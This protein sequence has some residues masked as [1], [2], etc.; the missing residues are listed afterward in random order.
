MSLDATIRFN[1]QT[2]KAVT[3]R[4]IPVAG[5][6]EEGAGSNLTFQN[7]SLVSLARSYTTVRKES[8]SRKSPSPSHSTTRTSS[9][10]SQEG[11]ESSASNSTQ[12]RGTRANSTS[13]PSSHSHSETGIISVTPPQPI[14]QVQDFAGAEER[15][16]VA[17]IS[18]SNSPGSRST[19]ASSVADIAQILK[20]R[21]QNNH[22][23]AT[24]LP[25]TVDE[26]SSSS[27]S[28]GSKVKIPSQS[29]TPRPRTEQ[30][31]ALHP[32]RQQ[33]LQQEG[34]AEDMIVVTRREELNLE[35]QKEQKL[36]I[37][38][39]LK[40]ENQ[41]KAEEQQQ[42]QQRQRE[43]EREQERKRKEVAEHQKQIEQERQRLEIERRQAEILEQQRLGEQD[44]QRKQLQKRQL[45]QRQKQRE[46]AEFR[47][48]KAKEE[49]LRLERE[50][51][52][53]I[54]RQ[55]DF[56]VSIANVNMNRT[57]SNNLNNNA[58]GNTN[59]Q[60][61]AQHANA[62]NVVPNNSSAAIVSNVAY[63]R[64]Q[65][66]RS[67]T[68][69]STD[70]PMKRPTR[71][72]PIHNNPIDIGEQGHTSP[73]ATTPFFDKMVSEEMQDFK[74]FQRIVKLQ[75]AQI[76]EL[77][78]TNNDMERRL[79]FQTRERYELETTLEEQEALWKDKCKTLEG[80]RDDLL[81]CLET[82][83]TT[84]AKLWDL[85]IQKEKAIQHAHQRRVSNCSIFRV[86]Y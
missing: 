25:E 76:A 71:N 47:A 29:S 37:A 77:K 86:Y 19:S 10:S 55:C 7:T 27:S 38:N 2:K 68:M 24:L 33:Q 45:Q 63:N 22:S 44:R 28:S 6:T 31:E 84:N 57:N 73:I 35:L 1:P 17:E 65:N 8:I 46:E 21:T 79:E 15:R 13:T 74:D 4:S 34:G 32:D 41:I 56:P 26:V 9:T 60:E 40:L 18:A 43:E 62:T 30:R 48:Q 53:K 82:E 59:A 12:P 69:S 39:R 20:P 54:E 49:Q 11:S 61:Q 72:N 50:K 64:R 81:R 52:E 70:T 80:E 42:L 14:N 85:V 3:A 36:K 23:A 58:H 16:V 5:Q 66:Q 51:K 78:T 75:H 83:K 67:G